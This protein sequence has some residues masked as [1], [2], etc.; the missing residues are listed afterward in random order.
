MH[1]IAKIVVMVVL[2]GGAE[3]WAVTSAYA[4]EAEQSVQEPRAF[5]LNDLYLD[6]LLQAVMRRNQ[7]LSSQHRNVTI[8]RQQL[9]AERSIFEPD[10]VVSANR[11]SN[12]V[13]NT[14][15]E[16]Y[17]RQAETLFEETNNHYEAGVEG[18]LP[19]GGTYRLGYQL[20][21]L[22]NSL[23]DLGP[24][25]LPLK[26]YQDEYRTFF[27]VT[28]SQPLLKNGGIGTT[29]AKIHMAEADRGM[30]FQDYRKFRLRLAAEAGEAYWRVYGAREK[31]AL[32]L[33][34]LDIAKRFLELSRHRLQA[35]KID[36][37]DFLDAKAGVQL[38]RALTLAARHELESAVR[39]LLKLLSLPAD[40]P[41]PEVVPKE[42]LPEKVGFVASDREAVQQMATFLELAFENHPEYLKA[43]KK[44]EREQVRVA[45]TKN[46][47]LPQI[48]LTG[49]YGFNGLEDTAGSSWDSA[50]Y[51]HHES[52]MIGLE[53]RIPFGGGGDS[54][55]K[56]REAKERKTQALEQIK[57]AEVRIEH[58]IGTALD[59]IRRAARQAE[60]YTEAAA[61]RA[62]LLEV[63]Q[64][65]YTAGK[66]DS[67]MLLNR[68]VDR[69]KAQEARLDAR[70]AHEVGRIRLQAVTGVL[71][72]HYGLEDTEDRAKAEEKPE[73]EHLEDLTPAE[74]TQQQ[75]AGAEAEADQSP[76]ADISSSPGPED[77]AST[78]GA[79]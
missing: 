18:L 55:S 71:L 21:D 56:L 10:F 24:D 23:R 59:F 27:G 77:A 19:L 34:S 43:R 78:K 74:E 9:N 28:L 15:E 47:R 52:W 8:S 76:A 42:A 22:S 35:G 16:K 1:I 60:L 29:L 7:K 73:T 14:I 31:L 2:M 51:D 36:R 64:A 45:Y 41:L 54:R 40:G 39:N 65:R 20:D 25:G 50:V 48:D 72:Q 5:D 3:A 67:W 61:A 69:L 57:A 68:E 26:A 46:Q 44:A 13:Q 6:D 17:T 30:S 33:H 12:E 63:E 70:L 66:S 58:D 75:A 49:S 79:E 4:G 53:L 32:R 37:S 38:R 11:E 62:K